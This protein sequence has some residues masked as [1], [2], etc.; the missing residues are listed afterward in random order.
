MKILDGID[1]NIQPRLQRKT[2][3]YNVSSD[4]AK[5]ISANINVN[6][7]LEV[8]GFSF[9]APKNMKTFALIAEENRPNNGGAVSRGSVISG[10][11]EAANYA[12]VASSVDGKVAGDSISTSG[13]ILG[14][15]S[16]YSVSLAN[17]TGGGDAAVV[18]VYTDSDGRVLTDS[19]DPQ[20]P[21]R[22]VLNGAGQIDVSGRIFGILGL[23]DRQ[24]HSSY[25]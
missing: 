15:L 19:G 24:F 1:L 25:P 16:G 2:H 3:I 17:A 21:M 20:D 14:A 5:E 7:N 9:S 18:N 22:T 12:A 8:T 13:D 10:I 11:G 6:G 23:H 4:S